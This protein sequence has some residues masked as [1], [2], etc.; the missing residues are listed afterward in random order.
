[1]ARYCSPQLSVRTRLS[2][3]YRATIRLKVFH[4]R[5]SISWAKSKPAYASFS[6]CSRSLEPTCSC[7]N[8]GQPEQPVG[9]GRR[10]NGSPGESRH[11][12]CEI[13]SPVE[14]VFELSEISRHVLLVDRSIRPNDGGFDISQCRIDPLEAGGAGRR[15]AR[16]GLDDLMGAPGLGHGTETSQAIADDL[17]RRIEA[18]PGENRN[19]VFAETG[20]PTQLQAHRL[21]LGRGLDG[22]DERRLAGGAATALA[23]RA[24]AA[25][26]GVVEFDP[27]G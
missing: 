26:I 11:H 16:A 2:P 13:V 10:P 6:A 1:M 27:P 23:A 22:G 17:V 3:S 20:H 18:T 8:L 9:H 25:E 24:F 4:G 21:G 14:A 15:S 19:R 5:N 12:G 7:I